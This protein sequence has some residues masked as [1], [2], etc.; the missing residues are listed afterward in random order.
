MTILDPKEAALRR[1]D[2]M[3][4]SA[5]LKIATFCHENGLSEEECDYLLDALR[6]LNFYQCSLNDVLLLYNALHGSK[7]NDLEE[8]YYQLVSAVYTIRKER[9]VFDDD[10]DE[11]ED[12]I[13]DLLSLS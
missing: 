6:E 8:A 13:P 1:Y 5:E 3:S 2:E 11:D 12:E 4:D 10:E 9:K 7:R